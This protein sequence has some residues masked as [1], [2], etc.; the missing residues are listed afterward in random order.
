MRRSAAPVL[1]L[2]AALVGAG[3]AVP[4]CGGASEREQLVDE[5]E[6]DFDMGAEQADCVADQLYERFSEDEIATLREADGREDVP[7]EL[8]DA[9]RAALTPCAGS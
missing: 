3:A 1:A 2:L 4:A 5:L 9:L 8:L 6:T 7:E